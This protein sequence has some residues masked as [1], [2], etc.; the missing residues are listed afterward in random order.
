MGDLD[1]ITI[2]K[3][4]WLFVHS[5]PL[6]TGDFISAVGDRGV[7][8]SIEVLRALARHRLLVPMF[9][10][11]DKPCRDPL[12]ATVSEPAAMSTFGREFRTARQE[13]RLSDPFSNPLSRA[14]PF[15]DR[16]QDDPRGWWN[17]LLY[18]RWQVVELPGIVG[19]LRAGRWRRTPH[20]RSLVLP[21][22]DVW[23]RAGVAGW[24]QLA[25]LLT[26]LESRYAP[27]IDPDWIRLVNADS[28]QWSAYRD[29]YEPREAADRLGVTKDEAQSAAERMLSSANSM[30][31]LGSWHRLV[32]QADPKSWEQLKD[33]ARLANDLR[34]AAEILLLFTEDLAGSPIPPPTGGW[35][36]PRHDRLSRHDEPLDRALEEF[37]LSPHTRMTL[38][39]E[40][41]SEAQTVTRVMDHLGIPRR[42]EEIHVLNMRGVSAPPET[43]TAP[44]KRNRI[45]RVQ[46]LATHLI[47]PV[48]TEAMPD[49]YVTL[50]PIAQVTIAADPEGEFTNPAAFK[51][52]VL[53]MVQQN[54]KD[55]DVGDVGANSLQQ[56]IDVVTWDQEFEFAHF[57][58]DELIAALT[59]LDDNL[60]G[61]SPDWVREQLARCRTGRHNIR[62]V[63]EGWKPK[64]SKTKLAEAL[65]PALRHCIDLA[66]QGL[67]DSPAIAKVVHQAHQEAIQA[68]RTHFVLPRQ[69]P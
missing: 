1:A 53:A 10:V 28:V 9:A 23:Q 49:Y 11:H 24:H 62:H 22:P 17:G 63:W 45:S 47:T 32:R 6:S 3:E 31:P 29:E 15:R 2:A 38:I 21:T 66:A 64:P 50:R 18:S 48:I 43:E 39:V 8:L 30:D 25:L 41:D 68:R 13:G 61:R 5:S 33:R 56:L 69:T 60:G 4:P 19:A 52:K 65:W 27:R 46:F 58:D 42:G 51:A 57:T 35:W 67:A 16:T 12:P 34:V 26:A 20:G 40:G 44:G 14:W 36:T 59:A 7:D 37:G 54:L 55:Q